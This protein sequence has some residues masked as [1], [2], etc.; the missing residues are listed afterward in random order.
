[1]SGGEGVVGW[2]ERLYIYIYIYMKVKGHMEH[3]NLTQVSHHVR[4]ATGRKQGFL[5]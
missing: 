5:L 4:R 1:M 3:D 2:C